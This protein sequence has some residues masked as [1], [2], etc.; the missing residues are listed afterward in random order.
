VRRGFSLIDV[1]VSMA[2]IA[3]LISILMPCLSSVRETARQ[4]ICR[5]NMRQVGYGLGFYAESHQDRL[6]P[7]VYYADLA[8]ALP[9]ETIVLR[10]TN[11]QWDGL[12]LLYTEEIMPAPRI[13]YCP[14]H[15][16]DHPFVACADAWNGSGEVVGNIQYR[17]MGPL[18]AG[19]GMTDRLSLIAP[20]TTLLVDG[21]RTVEDFNHVIGANVFRADSSVSWYADRNHQ[22]VTLL[23]K[24]GTPSNTTPVDQI[25]L[26]LDRR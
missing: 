9:L 16:G 6:P 21:L 15:H 19:S 10:T 8:N 17:P 3:I 20:G 1:L 14:S 13:F 4:I 22:V 7:S 12:G 26:E 2:V 24:D 18:G 5:S 11:G 25:W 23:P